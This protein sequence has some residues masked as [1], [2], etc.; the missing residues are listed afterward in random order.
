M[1]VSFFQLDTIS[2]N[3]NWVNACNVDRML[4]SL[5]SNFEDVKNEIIEFRDTMSDWVDH[6]QLLLKSCFGMN[7]YEF[8]EFLSRISQNR[9]NALLTKS[10]LKVGFNHLNY[11][12]KKLKYVRTKFFEHPDVDLLFR[13]ENTT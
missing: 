12:L 7:F 10:R 9:E 1:T 4:A 6:C 11:D 5:F 2:I 8:N 3:H 13:R